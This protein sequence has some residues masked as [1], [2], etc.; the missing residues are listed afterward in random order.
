M[1]PFQF[2]RAA[3]PAE[4]VARVREHRAA[5]F[6]AG[7]TNLVDLMR[8]G[9]ESPAT[10]IDVNRLALDAIEP[11]DDGGLRIGATVR[12]S[13]LAA[14]PRVRERYPM[15]ASALLHGASGQVRNL[16]TTA[17][18]LLQRT[19]CPYFY[20]PAKPCNKREPGTGCPAREGEHHNLAIIGA[21]EA[22]IATHPSDMAVAMAAL[23]ARVELL[24]AEGTRSIPLAELHRLPGETPHLETNLREGELIMSVTLPN[25]PLA[26]HSRYVKVRE[27]A[28][29]AFALVSVAAA[30][31][32]QDGRVADVR[33]ALG[34]VAPLPWRAHR[35]EEVLRGASPGA[36]TFT[37]A[38]EAELAAAAP[39]PGNAYKVPLTRNAI[40]D[41]LSDLT[42]SERLR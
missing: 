39:L 36:E 34:G 32:V 6:L 38:A 22:C 18:N 20:D 7:G 13:V 9:I 24:S 17:G 29:F 2:V 8:L 35:A 11:S 21:S 37:R 1:R 42:E 26:R 40:V 33:L 19:R 15:L 23:D 14:D 4:A 12:N 25:L 27:R 31:E 16:A 30:L 5:R 10:L 3:E 28:S 41:V